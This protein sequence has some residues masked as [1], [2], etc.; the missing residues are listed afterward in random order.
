MRGAVATMSRFMALSN[1]PKVSECVKVLADRRLTQGSDAYRVDETIMHLVR[2]YTRNFLR[3]S[4]CF[5]PK[6]PESHNLSRAKNAAGTSDRHKFAVKCLGDTIA[7]AALVKELAFSE[8]PLNEDNSFHSADLGSGTG[9]L[10]VGAAIAGLRAGASKVILNIVDCEDLT[11]EMAADTLHSVGNHVQCRP[12]YGDITELRTYDAL[13]VPRVRMWISETISDGTPPLKI[14]KG[15]VIF[16]EVGTHRHDIDPFPQVVA[17]LTKK[18][19]E[20]AELVTGGR[21]RMFPDIFNGLYQPGDKNV[22][23]LL[24]SKSHSTHGPLGSV[25]YD[26]RKYAPFNTDSRW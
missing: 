3:V 23:R 15:K 22:L 20:L 21:V 16:T 7:T 2:A 13:D 1:P 18:V 25:G 14:V 8:S 24:T 11:L 12:I 4:G 26:F 6:Q 19:P 9:V 10:S 17:C 5:D